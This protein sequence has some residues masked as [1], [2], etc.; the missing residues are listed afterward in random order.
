[1]ST[2][3]VLF[4]ALLACIGGV[5]HSAQLPPDAVVL[6]GGM[7]SSVLHQCSRTTP[8]IGSSTWQPG[9][10]D[11]LALERALPKALTAQAA[12]GDPDWSNAPAGWR[13]QYVGIV[14]KGR[15]L[16][17]GNFFPD[18]IEP[19]SW[20]TKP[21]IVCDGGAPFFGVVYDVAAH[22]ITGLAFN[23]SG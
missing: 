21:Q 15:R 6:P 11:I 7:A 23:G 14:L 5:A 3:G 16:I 9:A 2:R 13:R 8:A 19:G 22:R 1:M 17:Y 18:G 10:D 20:R 4:A 12:K